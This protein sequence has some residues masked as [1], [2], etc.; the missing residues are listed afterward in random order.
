MADVTK[1]S[2]GFGGDAADTRPL[3]RGGASDVQSV[4]WNDATTSHSPYAVRHA[5]WPNAANGSDV[6]QAFLQ[7]HLTAIL[8]P[9]A[10]HVQELQDAVRQL[11]AALHEA[12]AKAEHIVH[13]A[14]GDEQALEDYKQEMAQA[15]DAIRAELRPGDVA[16][17]EG[18]GDRI[19]DLEKRHA[20]T[21]TLAAKAEQRLEK[22]EQAIDALRK[23]LHDS[24][25]ARHESDLKLWQT[26]LHAQSLEDA[27]PSLWKKM[28]LLEEGHQDLR[29]NVLQT[30]A[31]VDKLD[32]IVGQLPSKESVDTCLKAATAATKTI[33]TINER[34]QVLEQ[35]IGTVRQDTAEQVRRLGPLEDRMEETLK[36]LNKLQE[37]LQLIGVKSDEAL[38]EAVLR[39]DRLDS[40]LA[41]LQRE[42]QIEQGKAL[43]QKLK[44]VTKQAQNT[45]T[46]LRQQGEVVAMLHTDAGESAKQIADL[47]ARLPPLETGQQKTGEQVTVLAAQ[48]E[49]LGH[50]HTALEIGLAQQQTESEKAQ[51]A[52][53]RVNRDLDSACNTIKNLQEALD[54]TNDDISRVASHLDLAHDY[55]HGMSKGV[56][57][58]HQK[59]SLGHDGLLPPKTER[60]TLPSLPAPK[61]RPLSG[62]LATP[63]A[64]S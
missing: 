1:G 60:R 6:M 36:K 25:A 41:A 23:A 38:P 49:D 18:H 32:V 58:T 52:I 2:P 28:G 63:R 26:K 12:D 45:A 43:D 19:D 3:S 13:R 8:H 11:A 48:L 4:G 7:Q 61:P 5:M 9:V 53:K 62:N 35:T 33:G 21:G 46:E 15:L 59:V 27:L 14:A 56:Q 31:M 20:K 24:D 10:E 17:L 16:V 44:D 39:L 55:L 42:M 64:G 40:G 34:H 51:F 57:D 47:A 50:V 22:A 29:S 30:R 54:Q 37:E